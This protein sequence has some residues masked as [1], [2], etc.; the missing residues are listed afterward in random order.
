LGIDQTFA[1]ALFLLWQNEA[2]AIE[3]YTR[4]PRG[5]SHP[6][7][8]YRVRIR[9]IVDDEF[10][11]VIDELHDTLGAAKI[12]EEKHWLSIRTGAASTA[13]KAQFWRL[14]EPSIEEL[15]GMYA[16]RETPKR[17]DSGRGIEKKRL[18]KTI[19][20]V[21]VYIN[22]KPEIIG[23]TL[24]PNVSVVQGKARVGDILAAAC[25]K[26]HI[27][28]Y[29]EL[30]SK[31]VGAATINREIGLLS[32]AFEM[33]SDYWP[34]RDKISNPCKELK[35]G[36]R[37]SL[38]KHRER[39]LALAEETAMLEQ[40]D[41]IA[42]PELALSIRIALGSAMRRGDI[43]AMDWAHLDW[44]CHVVSIPEDKATRLGKRRTGR[45]AIL[46]PVAYDALLLRWEK[47]EKPASG[48][49]FSYSLE[50]FK[51]AWD[52]L[53]VKLREKHNIDDLRFHD[54]RHTAI[55]R[56]ASS[57][58]S[59]VQVAKAFDVADLE[60]LEKRFFSDKTAAA[61]KA[62]MNG[63]PL[64]LE[65]LA[66]IGG[67]MDKAMVARYANL[68][69]E[70]APRANNQSGGKPSVPEIEIE[71]VG[72]GFVAKVGNIRLKAETAKAAYALA[73][74]LYS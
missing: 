17:A 63:D 56:A 61:A 60:H 8:K 57:G 22:T 66:A 10:P 1:Q 67:H 69:P 23:K 62:L 45:K 34:E 42:N 58:W 5:Q 64:T 7:T 32:A 51:S 3:L 28:S 71:K 44:V 19:P 2:M 74:D 24:K 54:L 6:I 33:Y 15:L 27:L 70:D 49:V 26:Q 47:E 48:K 4:K 18:E 9:T 12:A 20:N 29:I 38:P 40:A 16:T 25:T 68:R 37:P 35:Q 21:C 13:L 72:D 39:V 43:L 73:M 65:E 31:K 59:S 53:Q 14:A 55:T 52:R 50:G 41:K 30:R 36:Q 11:I 46:L